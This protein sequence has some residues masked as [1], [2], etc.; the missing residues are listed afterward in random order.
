MILTSETFY[1]DVC[2]CVF[3]CLCVFVCIFGDKKKL[4]ITFGVILKFYPCNRFSPRPFCLLPSF[5]CFFLRLFCHVTNKCFFYCR[6][7][8]KVISKKYLLVCFFPFSSSSL[9]TFLY[10]SLS[11][12]LFVHNVIIQPFAALLNNKNCMKFFFFLKYIVT[13]VKNV[14]KHDDSN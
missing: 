5:F 3:A 13:L 1:D 8:K 12:S 10:V 11:L 9:F 6:P 7:E 14:T 4:K 2:S